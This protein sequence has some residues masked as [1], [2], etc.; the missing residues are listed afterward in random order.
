MPRTKLAGK[1]KSRQLAIKANRAAKKANK[2]NNSTTLSVVPAVVHLKKL[3]SKVHVFNAKLVDVNRYPFLKSDDTQQLS[4]CSPHSVEYNGFTYATVQHAYQAQ[5]YFHSNNP[6][7]TAM[8]YLGGSIASSSDA[9]RAG[10]RKEM[11]SRG[12]VINQRFFDERE[13]IMEDLVASKISRHADIREIL[14]ACRQHEFILVQL[15]SQVDKYWD[16]LFNRLPII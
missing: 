3:K 12:V 11:L 13:Q 5:K 16:E 8:F 1:S 10:S 15:S 2:A 4:N 9:T 6:E 7:L 14:H